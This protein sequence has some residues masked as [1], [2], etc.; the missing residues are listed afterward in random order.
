M[1]S[2]FLLQLGDDRTLRRKKGLYWTL[3]QQQERQELE[4]ITTQKSQ[5]G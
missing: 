5:S 4:E 1:T 3:V 2:F